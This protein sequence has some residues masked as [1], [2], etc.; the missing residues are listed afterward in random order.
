M[1]KKYTNFAKDD[2][3]ASSRRTTPEHPPRIQPQ[4]GVGAA[5]VF[6]HPPTQRFQAP[7]VP[8]AKVGNPRYPMQHQFSDAKEQPGCQDGPSIS[9][10]TTT[11][12]TVTATSTSTDPPVEVNKLG[13]TIQQGVIQHPVGGTQPGKE[14]RFQALTKTATQSGRD[15]TTNFAPEPGRKWKK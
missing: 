2:P 5:P 11:L 1:C 4:Q 10:P 8:P 7:V 6:P 14:T 13:P 9:T 15:N 3:I 12:F